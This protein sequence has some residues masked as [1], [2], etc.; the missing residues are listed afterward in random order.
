M[1]AHEPTWTAL[2]P[3]S[4]WPKRWAKGDTITAEDAAFL[5]AGEPGTVAALVE[6]GVIRKK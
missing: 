5:E 4:R 1:P 6:G 2:A 3:V